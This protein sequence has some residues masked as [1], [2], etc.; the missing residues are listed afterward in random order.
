MIERSN[1]PRCQLASIVMTVVFILSLLAAGG[2]FAQSVKDA[3]PAL[4]LDQYLDQVAKRHLGVQA[5]DQTARA[6]KAYA[7]DSSTFFAP[8]LVA[9]VSDS[10]EGRS[11][12]LTPDQHFTSQSYSLGVTQAT[13][14][15]LSAKL[16]YNYSFLNIPNYA[17]YAS[18]YGQLDLT[19]SLVRNFGAREIK[20]QVDSTE[21][22]AL[23]KSFTQSYLSKSLILEAEQY[24][25]RLAVA[26]EM[27]QMQKDAVDRAQKIYDWTSRR[28]KLQLTDEA[29]ML[30]ASTNLQ[31][32]RLDLR[33][34]E[35]DERAAAQA[36]NAS[37]GS[38]SDQVDDRLLSLVPDLIER[39]RIPQQHGKRDDVVAAE[40][41]ARLSAASAHLAREKDKPT[42]ELFA[43]AL[44][45]DP[46]AAPDA[47]NTVIP[48]S[49]RPASVVGIRLNA[50]LDLGTLSRAR[51][52]YEAEATAAQWQLQRKVFEEDRDWR[53]LTAKFGENKARF[54]LYVDLEKAQKQKLDYE[55]ERQKRGRST[56]QQV[57]L[58][59]TDYDQA[60]LGRIR[61]AADL[62]TLNA[63]L[64]LYGVTNES[65]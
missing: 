56:L 48:I 38:V 43:T 41:Q 60:Q 42:V 37:R 5:A 8:A 59:E 49:Y 36:F 20:A 52:G 24:Y 51:E 27:V 1:T 22:S 28:T 11:N 4:T 25:W 46:A 55:R 14:I 19:Q 63:Q 34:A 33:T 2:A 31:S 58:F 62:L 10:S 21:A 17:S 40:F 64:K 45:N 44:L 18:G 32:R 26:R 13:P 61:T 12:P 16:S 50:P 35:D 23:T 6:A 53:D 30:Q 57:L 29:E 47:I 15:G 9:N 54:K 7:G 39:M 65:R 3:T